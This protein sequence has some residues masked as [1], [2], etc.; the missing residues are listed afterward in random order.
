M[1]RSN[2]QILAAT[3][4]HLDVL[5]EHLDRGPLDDSLVFDA[6]CLRL[7]AA[8]EEIG[9]LDAALLEKQF[10]DSW[11]QIRATR[12][13]IA[14]GYSMVDS[15]LISTTVKVSLPGFVESI[16]ALKARLDHPQ[17]DN[18]QKSL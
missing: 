5:S 7:A 2:L 17:L 13:A 6:V 18:G 3:L 8:I 4:K 15:K 11:P 14:H 10:G 12:N 16:K 9:T 1:K